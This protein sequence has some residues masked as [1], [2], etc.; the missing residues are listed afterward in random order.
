MS[1]LNLD[2][3]LS[4]VL[5]DKKRLLKV[6]AEMKDNNGEKI[7]LSEI[8]EELFKYIDKEFAKSSEEKSS[9]ISQVMP[10][11]SQV[12]GS[13]LSRYLG[14]EQAVLYLTDSQT[15]DALLQMMMLSF[16]LLKYIQQKDIQVY[17]VSEPIEKVEIEKLEMATQKNNQKLKEFLNS[18][19]SNQEEV[20]VSN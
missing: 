4:M 12:L 11:L 20:K 7:N 1:E 6:S 3:I 18:K 13:G 17:S 15:K 10:L 9:L 2:E 16:L 8:V 5:I 14:V 19:I